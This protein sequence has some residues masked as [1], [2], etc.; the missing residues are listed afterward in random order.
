M[1][2]ETGQ[3]PRLRLVRGEVEVPGGLGGEPREAPGGWARAPEGVAMW[4]G[5]GAQQ[6]GA[7][8]GRS[9]VG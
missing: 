1:L 9:G 2:G 8:Q 4:G 5:A 6:R 7:A 3:A